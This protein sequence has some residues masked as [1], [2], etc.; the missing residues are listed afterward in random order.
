M[1]DREFDQLVSLVVEVCGE[2]AI[3]QAM[4][5]ALWQVA[6][7]PVDVTLR[8][9]VPPG[10]RDRAVQIDASMLREA[11]TNELRLLLRPH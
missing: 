6:H 10:R 11:M 1:S 8:H 2:N 7:R 4:A 3:E 5:R 9:F